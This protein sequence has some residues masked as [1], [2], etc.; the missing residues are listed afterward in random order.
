MRTSTIIGII[1]IAFGIIALAYQGFTYKDRE[2]VLDVG[3]I[4][5]TAETE[6]T[7]PISPIIGGVAVVSGIILLLAGTRKV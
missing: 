4:K 2:T 5:A 1:L 6:K 7:V 3:P